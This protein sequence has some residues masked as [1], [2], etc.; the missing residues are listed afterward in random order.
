MNSVELIGIVK[1]R[2]D[3]KSSLVE[4][5]LPCYNFENKDY[6]SIVCTYWPFLPNSRFSS[7]EEG[8]RVA[9]RGHLDVTKDYATIV[10]VESFEVL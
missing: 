5:R 6:Q 3:E 1:K 4:Y 2:I 9:I 7:L 8:T 10:I